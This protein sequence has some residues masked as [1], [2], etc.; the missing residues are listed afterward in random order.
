M[1]LVN[2]VYQYG[3]RL[4]RILWRDSN[5]AYW[6]DIGSDNALPE[7]ISV[8]TL[9]KLLEEENISYAADPFESFLLAPPSNTDRG[10]HIQSTSWAMI[11]AYV[12]Q[13]PDI[14]V[15]AKRGKMIQEILGRQKT[16]KQT[17]YAKFRTYWQRGKSPNGLYPD[18]R[19]CGGA[20]K[21]KS[22]GDKKRGRPRTVSK[23]T[24]VNIDDNIANV[25][26]AIIKAHY[27]NTKGN[28][29]DFA[30][31]QSLIA[32][33]IDRTKVTEAELA[34]A[35]T[36]EQFYHFIQKEIGAV[37]KARKR[38][39]EIQ[40]QKDMRPVL[41]TSAAEVMGPGSL[42]QIDATIGDIYLLAENDRTK[43]I[44]RPVIYVVIDVFSRLVTGV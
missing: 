22:A 4:F 14:Y 24:G 37:E 35:P 1:L 40:F 44:G 19:N 33:G 34:E 31:N 25:F 18:T 20:G 6:I 38:V 41:G 32:L 39:G 9:I 43:I 11:S 26:R 29:V 36:Y 3:R 7:L 30:Y 13:E 28:T 23:G 10:K 16:T 2:D 12:V 15:R 5:L 21:A 17:V 27:L 42:Y 8:A